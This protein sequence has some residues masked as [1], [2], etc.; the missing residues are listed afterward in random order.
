MEYNVKAEDYSIDHMIDDDAFEIQRVAHSY[1]QF[2]LSDLTR[3][4]H[5]R[6][7]GMIDGGKKVS[8]D[9]NNILRIA[10]VSH[11]M[12]NQSSEV[13][14]IRKGNEVIKFA[15]GV[16]YEDIDVAVTDF[17]GA[18]VERIIS[19]WD[20]LRYNPRTGMINKATKYKRTGH[21]IQYSVDGSIIRSWLLKGAWVNSVKYGEYDR[22]NA[23]G[24]RNI[25]FTIHVDKAYP[26]IREGVATQA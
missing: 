24:E 19:A 16:S 17:V 15:G 14:S 22:S 2:E 8:F 20:A 11:G 7:L 6:P 3:D 1:I 5:D 21:I 9:V 13:I 23:T 25:S 4:I 10:L 26:E 12:P 18:D